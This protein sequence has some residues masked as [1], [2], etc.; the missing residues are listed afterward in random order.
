MASH[1]TR[2]DR[3]VKHAAE[4]AILLPAGYDLGHV[5]MGRGNLWG[6]GELNLERT[7]RHGITYRTVM[8]NFFMEIER[9]LRLGV[10]FD[11]LWDLEGLN[12][13]DYREVVRVREDGRVE[14]IADGR[15]SE[16]SGP[17]VPNRP[18]G[19]A[20]KLTVELSDGG[21][22]G[23]RAITARAR[24]VQQASPVYYTTGTDGQGVY[25]NAR[26]LWE[27][28]GPG[29]ED[30]RALLSAGANP[31]TTF[32]GVSAVVEVKFRVEQTGRYRLRSAT[33]DL[34]GRSTVV[35]Q[36]IMARK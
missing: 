16:H 6:L 23:P 4:V 15:R 33:T 5:H 20:P 2:D 17:R 24:V 3:R 28:Y 14:V 12:L 19:A 9:C 26:V 8:G 36:E 25:H 34:A 30:Y 22:R 1:P 35:W 31:P 21:E 13:G 10:A 11:L 27:L 32:D 18:A 29:D 7:N